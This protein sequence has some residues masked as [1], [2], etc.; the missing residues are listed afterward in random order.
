MTNTKQL[1]NSSS[2][3]LYKNKSQKKILD[4]KILKIKLSGITR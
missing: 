3:E 4:D 2:I 1:T